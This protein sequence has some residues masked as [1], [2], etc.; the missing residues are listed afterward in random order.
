[1]NFM[2]IQLAWKK[3]LWDGET[4]MNIC[5]PRGMKSDTRRGGR[6]WGS[7]IPSD[8]SY[9][10]YW[11]GRG[12]WMSPLTSLDED[13]AWEAMHCFRKLRWWVI[14][15][16][17]TILNRQMQIIELPSNW[18]FT[19]KDFGFLYMKNSCDFKAPPGKQRFPFPTSFWRSWRGFKACKSVPFTLLTASGKFQTEMSGGHICYCF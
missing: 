16:K 1:M 4:H 9:S 11:F 6:V 12:F 17:S 19:V 5:M 3:H 7:V 15:S 13:P 18:S 2:A 10:V 14:T 8:H